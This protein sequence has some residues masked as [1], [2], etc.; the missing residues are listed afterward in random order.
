MWFR[1]VHYRAGAP[2]HLGQPPGLFTDWGFGGHR[3][4]HHDGRH[5]YRK[6]H[7]HL[8]E[9]GDECPIRAPRGGGWPGDDGHRYFPLR[10]WAIERGRSG[11]CTQDGGAGSFPEHGTNDSAVHHFCSVRE[12]H[13]RGR[14]QQA[15]QGVCNP[16][17]AAHPP[18][19]REF[20]A[21][22]RAREVAHQG[23]PPMKRGDRHRN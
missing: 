1:E 22:M 16:G 8:P 6:P 18:H 19:G 23:R 17:D 5:G 12:D 10:Y 21:A 11:S 13:R 15:T 9:R 14:P 2:D 3:H 7:D 20:F 4:G